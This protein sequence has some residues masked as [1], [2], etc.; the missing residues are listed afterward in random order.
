MSLDIV[1]ILLFLGMG[2]C[3]FLMIAILINRKSA[4]VANYL[5]V[6]ILFAFLWYQFEFYL[7]RHTLESQIPF[8]FSTRYGSWLVVGPLIL[9][10]NRAI[11][12]KDFK[13]RANTIFHFFPFIIFTIILPLLFNDIVTTRATH[14][15]MLTVFDSWN[16]EEITVRHYLYA[17]V[18]VLQFLHAAIYTLLAY[19]ES[20]QLSAAA[21]ENR[22]S[23]PT[24]K[25]RSLQ[26]LYLF[27]V[28]IILFCS[29]FVVY[30][31][32]TTIWRNT[33]DY[34]YMLPTLI[35]VYGLAYRAIKYPNS[36]II[37]Q[38]E[39]QV[40]KYA[41]SSL[42]EETV[43]KITNELNAKLQEDKIYRKSDLRL[44]DLANELATSGHH[45]SQVINESL[46]QNFFDLINSYR[47][48]EAKELIAKGEYES[49][50]E[51][52]YEVGFNSKNSFNN[53]FKRS[54]GITP[55]QFKKSL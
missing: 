7:L 9:L 35:F 22:S 1:S 19:R 40:P 18:F 24:H 25:I 13:L 49:L 44:Q 21:K 29:A 31:F 2:Q 46:G 41:K 16:Q 11:L 32:S 6:A 10:Y 30:L 36:I 48:M 43:R 5:L 47:V 20:R 50:L 53:A 45:L 33:Y 39:T 38:E 42:S 54:E 8:L 27:T 23:L 12:I 37:L 51:V 34:L 52:A 26:Y 28:V 4:K 14:Y 3:I 55:S 15:G 17:I